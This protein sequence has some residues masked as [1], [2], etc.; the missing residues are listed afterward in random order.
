[1]QMGTTERLYELLDRPRWVVSPVREP[2]RQTQEPRRSVGGK[3][4]V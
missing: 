4:R 3:T 2:V 1:M